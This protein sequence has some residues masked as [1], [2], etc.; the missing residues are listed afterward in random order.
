SRLALAAR[1]S[2]PDFFRSG[3]CG[4]SV[5]L[6]LGL[7]TDA[8]GRFLAEGSGV[9]D[10]GAGVGCAARGVFTGRVSFLDTEVESSGAGRKSI[11]RLKRSTLSTNTS[12]RA[13]RS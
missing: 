8:A 2:L 5:C 9:R 10:L 11:S 1:F 3:D 6:A 13:P 4:F 7:G 12:I